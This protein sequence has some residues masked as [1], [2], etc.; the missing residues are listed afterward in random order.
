MWRAVLTVV[1]VLASLGCGGGD[2]PEPYL[3][4]GFVYFQQQNYD[5]AI[6]SYEKAIALGGKSP[7]AY[8]MLGMAYRFKYQ[9]TNDPALQENEII[10]FE[11]A[12]VVDPKNWAAM[13]NLGNT[14]YARGEK[15]KAAN[16]F[17]QALALNPNHPEKAQIQKMIAEGGAAGSRRP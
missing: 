14:Y 3:K 1:L 8:N 5:K 10:A 6:E 9:Q 2:S 7:G 17:R 12:L 11:K 15:T 16:L 4:D 13:I